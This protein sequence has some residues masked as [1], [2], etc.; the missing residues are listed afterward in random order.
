MRRP[1]NNEKE[2]KVDSKKGQ[3]QFPPLTVTSHSLLV[4]GSDRAFRDLLGSLLDIGSQVHELRSFIAEQLGVSEPQYRVML[5]I[6]Q[7]QK[8]EGVSVGTVAERMWV[9][10]NFVTMEVRKLQSLGWVEKR[11][12]P[13]DGRGVLLCISQRG[14][15][16]F[17]SVIETIQSINNVMFDHM[18]AEEFEILARV[19]KRLVVHGRQALALARARD[20]SRT[21]E[22]KPK[23]SSPASTNRGRR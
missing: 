23:A 21:L 3:G 6:A 20:V 9:T 10:T 18:T 11:Q 7:M 13:D 12:N 4:A 14:R 8:E 1:K 22:A 16:A 2:V 5:A 15:E 17:T 19:S